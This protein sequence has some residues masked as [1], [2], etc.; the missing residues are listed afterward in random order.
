MACLVSVESLQS[1]LRGEMA[2]EA[3]ASLGSHVCQC[4]DCQAAVES[5]TKPSSLR[6]WLE[7]SPAGACES[8]SSVNLRR[9]LDGRHDFLPPR[10]VDDATLGQGADSP[11]SSSTADRSHSNQI[12]S[13]QLLDELGRGGMG[14]VY[15]AWDERSASGGRRQGAPPR[16]VRAGRPAAA[17]P[18]GPARR[19]ASRTIT[20]DDPRGGRPARRLPYLVME[21]VPGPT[22]RRKLSAADPPGPRQVAAWSWPRS[23]TRLTPPT[24]PA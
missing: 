14:I 18:R 10:A 19:P 2:P 17:G 7:A 24:P 15:R 23:P 20:R 1:W 11:A 16:A 12:G 3:A 22:L 9:F 21:Y 6:G 5:E 4:T 13:F 8:L